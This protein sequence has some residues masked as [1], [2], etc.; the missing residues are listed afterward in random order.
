MTEE[1]DDIWWWWLSFADDTGFLGV[2]IVQASLM[3]LAVSQAHS[4]GIN[5]GG[6]VFGHPVP[7][8]AL[9]KAVEK[10]PAQFDDWVNQLLTVKDMERLGMEPQKVSN[11][12][13][14]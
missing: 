4:L 6:E 12:D 9:R 2:A 8:V 1:H 14:K 7:E 5:P 3:E 10:S 13:G 11:L